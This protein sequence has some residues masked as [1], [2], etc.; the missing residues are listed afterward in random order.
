MVAVHE[1][2]AWPKHRELERSQSP[3]PAGTTIVSADSHVLEAFDWPDYV[4]AKYRD[5]A[6]TSHWDDTGFHLSADGRS[7]DSQGFPSEMMMGRPGARDVHLRIKD[8]DAEGISKDVL[9]PQ[10]C[11]GLIGNDDR[12]F[13]SACFRGYNELVMDHVNPYR[14]RLFPVGLIPFWDEASV[15]EGGAQLKDLG[16]KAM[17]MPTVPPG[18]AYNSR[19]HE[20]LWDAVEEIGLPLS[21]H[22][23]E[24]FQDRGPGGLA[25]TV[26]VAFGGFRYLWSLLTFSG[27]LER[28]PTLRV[29]FTEGGIGWIPSCLFDADKVYTAFESEMTP[30]WPIPPATTGS[31][32]ATPPSWTISPASS[33]STASA[34]TASCGPT[35]TPTR[36]APSA[37]PRRASRSASTPPQP[38]ATASASSARTPSTSGAWTTRSRS[39]DGSG[40]EI[41][42]CCAA[43]DRRRRGRRR[44]RS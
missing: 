24:N 7:L 37:T 15:R 13:V 22:V 18:V 44:P 29:V 38:S 23:G 32:T 36:R 19:E 33:S 5:R 31:T 6:P 2:R 1:S 10:L 30:G 39:D 11:Y 40:T 8:M 4:P 16:F 25:T 20:G 28:H 17:I 12:D 3:W 43:A 27:I 42:G 34:P 21:F 41:S 26:V 9:F 14:D 35:T